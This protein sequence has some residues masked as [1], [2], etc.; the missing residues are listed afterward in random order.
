MAEVEKRGRCG[1]TCE[2]NQIIIQW[3]I[4]LQSH[5][6]RK[7]SCAASI[8][9]GKTCRD[10]DIFTEIPFLIQMTA[11]IY[12]IV[13]GEGLPGHKIHAADRQMRL[14]LWR[15]KRNRSKYQ[16]KYTHPVEY[17]QIYRFFFNKQATPRT[18]NDLAENPGYLFTHP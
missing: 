2:G 12:R 7:V 8:E 11:V 18:L 4:Q 14:S 10:A 6:G 1:N 15:K 5:R 9:E 3:M 16:K 13:N 17:I